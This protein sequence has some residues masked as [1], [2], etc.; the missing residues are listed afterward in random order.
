MQTLNIVCQGCGEVLGTVQLADDAPP[1]VITMA[2][3]GLPC[4]ACAAKLK[5]HGDLS[6]LRHVAQS[7]PC[8]RL[9]PVSS[10]QRCP[11]RRNVWVRLVRHVASVSVGIRIYPHTQLAQ[12]AREK[13]II[14][15]QDDL[16]QPRFY[17]R[18]GLE[19]FSQLLPGPG[20]RG[21][22]RPLEPVQESE[23][24]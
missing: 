15:A 9:L 2:T 16:L 23:M 6:C 14:D 20:G 17:I 10:T 18:P 12:Q 13:G 24:W 21:L 7:L 4:D 3:Q 22:H 1:Y 11:G 8:G 19:T 5:Q